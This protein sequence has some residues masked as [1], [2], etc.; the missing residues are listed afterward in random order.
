MS[1]RPRFLFGNRKSKSEEGTDGTGEVGSGSTSGDKKGE[2]HPYKGI[3]RIPENCEDEF[4]H[5]YR[6]HRSEDAYPEDWFTHRRNDIRPELK[7][8]FTFPGVST[9]TSHPPP[10]SIANSGTSGGMNLH[11]DLS[12]ESSEYDYR[13]CYSTFPR[14]AAPSSVAS[15]ASSSR[16]DMLRDH[17]HH[18]RRGHQDQQEIGSVIADDEQLLLHDDL[19][20]MLRTKMN[21]LNRRTTA[22]ASP[23]DDSQSRDSGHSSSGGTAS[24]NSPVFKG[25]RQRPITNGNGIPRPAPSSS[26][27]QPSGVGSGLDRFS[28]WYDTN[29]HH[30]HHQEQQHSYEQSSVYSYSSA[31]DRGD[32]DSGV[33][34]VATTICTNDNHA[35]SRGPSKFEHEADQPTYW[36][37]NAM[38][39]SA[40]MSH[41]SIVEEDCLTRSSTSLDKRQQ[42]RQDFSRLQQST[43]KNPKVSMLEQVTSNSDDCRRSSWI[44]VCATYLLVV[45]GIFF[46]LTLLAIHHEVT[47]QRNSTSKVGGIF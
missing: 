29:H 14:P 47:C 36:T 15:V 4:L 3:Q 45:L 22:A 34:S 6:Q 17:P 19:S 2:K 12:R 46:L 44:H 41:R 40:A 23:R 10:A 20:G 31:R 11:H 1:R 28:A 5:Y 42:Q 33:S 27:R 38:S 21:L 37:P 8:S 7:H 26:S 35:A 16:L 39:M 32:E 24:N 18:R 43:C 30:H 25:L 9:V 13:S